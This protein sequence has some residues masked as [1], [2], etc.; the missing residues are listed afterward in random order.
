MRFIMHDWPNEQAKKILKH[1]GDAAQPST[2]LMLL[3]IIVPYSTL[4][5]ADVLDAP[6]DAPT[7]PIPY[8][9]LANL[10]IASMHMV[11]MDMH[12]CCSRIPS[13]IY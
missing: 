6:I 11:A 9:L 8:P 5:D 3:D 13:F 10:G 4:G 1:L 7:S 12:V 2:K